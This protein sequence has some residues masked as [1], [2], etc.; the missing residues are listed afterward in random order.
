M[1]EVSR[2]KTLWI[3]A[4]QQ[5]ERTDR[6]LNMA[7]INTTLTYFILTHEFNFLLTWCCLQSFLIHLQR[8]VCLLLFMKWRHH[9][10]SLKCIYSKH[11][12]SCTILKQSS[13][14]Y[15]TE[16]QKKYIP[17]LSEIK[18]SEMF[19]TLVNRQVQPPY[20]YSL[21]QLVEMTVHVATQNE[22]R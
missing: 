1:Y 11:I 9:I 18:I 17:I 5:S 13:S 21:E 3:I 7:S 12:Y 22:R 4:L 10:S 6:Q 14:S 16:Q 19:S 20:R 15:Y 8:E 2:L